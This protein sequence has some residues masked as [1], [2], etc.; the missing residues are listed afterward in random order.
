M[1]NR[2][3]IFWILGASLLTACSSA[4]LELPACDIPAPMVEVGHAVSVPEM[5]VETSRTDTSATFDR[6]GIVRLTQVRVA[7]ETNKRV[8]E[9]N[10][11]AIEARND[12]VNAL[13]ECSR[14]QKVWMEVREEM[15]K[16][17]RFDHTMDN[18]WHRAIILLGA[19]AVAL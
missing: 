18:Y 3:L 12:E 7:A 16:A 5:P 4:P 15:L 17:E 8:A 6:A 11:L 14:Y 1:T 9:E 19:L 10:A 2:W 13:I